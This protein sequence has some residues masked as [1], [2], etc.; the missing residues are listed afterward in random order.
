[1]LGKV[2]EYALTAATAKVFPG[3][4]FF[5]LVTADAVVDVEFF[6]ESGQPIGEFVGVL[7]G[8]AIHADDF[9]DLFNKRIS[10]FGKVKVTSATNQTIKAIVARVRCEYDRLA[11]NITAD[12]SV[13]ATL[14]SLADDSI[15]ATTT[16]QVAAADADRRAIIIT[17][18]ITNTAAVRV[19]DSGAGAANGIPLQ[20][21][22]SVTLETSAAVY[23]YNSHSAAQSVAITL[24]KD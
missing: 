12:V 3:G 14:D 4:R 8:F 6:D 7:G 20:P 11:G 21:G 23:V 15:A 5:R 9:L 2:Y 16:E 18:L 13:G 1:M 22:E 17:N 19:G 10:A 24:V